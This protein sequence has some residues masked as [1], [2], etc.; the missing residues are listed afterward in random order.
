M[1]SY[2]EGFSLYLD[3]QST[4]MHMILTY[5]TFLIQ[6]RFFRT[7]ARRSEEMLDHEKT[8]LLLPEIHLL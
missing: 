5:H 6:S 2:S 4:C 1:F 3:F 7:W 8:I